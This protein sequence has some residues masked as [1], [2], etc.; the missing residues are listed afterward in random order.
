MGANEWRES[1]TWP[2]P[3]RTRPIY[4]SG[5][6]G[7]IR[8][9]A[10]SP[11]EMPDSKSAFPADPRR[12][13]TDP[14]AAP[15]AH[16]YSRLAAREDVLTFDSEP[17]G[18]DMIVA[19]DVTAIVHASCDCAD[20]DLWVRLQD[21]HPDGRAFNLGGPGNDAVRASYR[22]PAAGRQAV[23]PGE[24]YEFRLPRAPTAIRFGK[25]HRIRVQVS[26]SFD[27]HL[28]RNLQTGRSEIDSAESRPAAIT[29]YHESSRPSRLLLPQ[30]AE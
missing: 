28:S 22:D 20:F 19:G 27:P 4:F 9:L 15:G 25:G 26:A 7:A 17:L 21:V 11:P 24:V 13:V 30:P 3:N 16:D 2:P 12:P 8:R 6:D 14:Y 1:A 18:E 23:V 10:S 29:V 5:G